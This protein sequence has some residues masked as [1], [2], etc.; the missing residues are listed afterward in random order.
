MTTTASTGKLEFVKS[1]GADKVIDYKNEKFEEVSE[2]YDVVLDCVGK[3][4][5]RQF[6]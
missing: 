6:M 4:R 5:T 2:K 1:L 3:P